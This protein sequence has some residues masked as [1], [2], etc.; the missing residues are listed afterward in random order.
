MWV[1]WRCAIPSHPGRGG[2][3]AIWDEDGNVYVHERLASIG[4]AY[5]DLAAFHE[6]TEIDHKLAGRSHAYAHRR[7][8]LLELLAAKEI[9]DS[10]EQVR[11]YVHRRI[12]GYPDRKV[13][14]KET[15]AS[16]LCG[17]L[18]QERSPRGKLLTVITEAG[19]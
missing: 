6:K 2:D 12:S 16:R 11:T 14:D 15:V 18:D 8:L 10:P 19:L 4:R 13:P 3:P 5:A 1:A 17:Y 9:Y 7:A